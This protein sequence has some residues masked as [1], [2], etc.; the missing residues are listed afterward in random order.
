MPNS[1]VS[2]NPLLVLLLFIVINPEP[3]SAGGGPW[4]TQSSKLSDDEK[5]PSISPSTNGNPT[6]PHC[7]FKQKQWSDQSN[8]LSNPHHRFLKLSDELRSNNNNRN[9]PPQRGEEQRNRGSLRSATR[10]VSPSNIPICYSPSHR[11]RSE[12]DLRR[13]CSPLPPGEC[14]VGHLRE[15]LVGMLLGQGKRLV[16]S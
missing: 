14:S 5:Q 7:N 3:Y 13:P 8:H 11:R 1:F 12:S 2:F 15:H 4:G 10:G 16:G 9:K 6:P